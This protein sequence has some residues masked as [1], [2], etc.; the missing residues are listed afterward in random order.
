M[1]SESAGFVVI[2]LAESVEF[3]DFAE[4]AVVATGGPVESAGVVTGELADFVESAEVAT[5][6]FAA[7][8]VAED[9]GYACYCVCALLRY[10]PMISLLR[11]LA[12]RQL[13]QC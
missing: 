8:V 2:E 1:K 11:K 4:P 6:D 7:A 12:G 10:G 5:G 3:A 9:A 13:A